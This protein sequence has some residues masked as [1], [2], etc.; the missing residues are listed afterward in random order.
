MLLKILLTSWL[1]IY[2]DMLMAQELQAT[3][4]VNYSQIQGTDKTVFD[5]L[6]TTLERFLNDRILN[7]LQFQ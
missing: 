5:N 2:S 4:N 3:V 7:A 1:L 6:Q